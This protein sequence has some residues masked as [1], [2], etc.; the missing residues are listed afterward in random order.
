[1]YSWMRSPA[2]LPRLA[3]SRNH[4]NGRLLQEPCDIDRM[5]A[6]DLTDDPVFGRMNGFTIHDFADESRLSSQRARLREAPDH[7]AVI[8][9]T[10]TN[11]LAADP[12]VL[13]YAG[14]RAGKFS[15]DTAPTRPVTW[16]PEPERRARAE[17]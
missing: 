13:I 8:V 14:C 3:P 12:D 11:L 10:G 4:P 1:V 17:V 2:L 9:G 15:S 16:P 5:V 6:R 7:L